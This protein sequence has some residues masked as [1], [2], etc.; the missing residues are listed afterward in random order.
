[1]LNPNHVR[2]TARDVVAEM[3]GIPGAPGAASTAV[4]ELESGDDGDGP[5]ELVAVTVNE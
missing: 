5:I 3:T 4:T 1:M 2:Q